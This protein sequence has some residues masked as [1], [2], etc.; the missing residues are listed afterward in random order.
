MTLSLEPANVRDGAR[1]PPARRRAAAFPDGEPGRRR[2]LCRIRRDDGGF[3]HLQ[4]FGIHPLA[5]LQFGAGDAAGRAMPGG[6]AGLRRHRRRDRSVLSRHDGLFGVDFRAAGAGGL[7][8]LPR[9]SRRVGDRHGSRLLRRRAGGA[10]QPLLA[11]RDARHELHAARLHHD[12]HAG[13]IDRLARSATTPPP[14]R[15]FPASSLAFPCRCSG[16]SALSLSPRC[17]SIATVSAP[18]STPSAIIPTAPRRWA[19][20]SIAS[21][22]RHSCSWDLA[23]RWRACS[24]R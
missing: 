9:H 8:S 1:R 10:R 3:H 12:R 5:D 2:Q 14:A 21:A 16:R 4:P 20:T 17:C 13:Q 23:R 15:F 7:Q 24:A 11:D 18:A 19:S 6:A 22:L